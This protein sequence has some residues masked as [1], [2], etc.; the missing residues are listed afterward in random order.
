MR[1]IDALSSG[2]DA[3]IT[4]A[5]ETGLN[6]YLSAPHPRDIAAYSSSTVSDISRAAFEHLLDQPP[7]QNA[8]DYG[9]VLD[10]IRHRVR[11]ECGLPGDTQIVF[12]ASGTD[13]EYV[14]LAATIGK[15]AKGVHNILLGADEIGSGCI[16][17]AN[18]AYFANETALGI[19]VEPADHVAGCGPV[20]MVDVPVRCGEGVARTS[21][22]ISAAIRAEI[23]TAQAAHKHALVHGVHGSKTGLVL[24]SLADIDAMRAEFAGDVTFVIDA[25]QARITSGALGEYVKR[26][27]IVLLTGSKFVGAPPFSGFALVPQSQVDGAA[28]L[29]SGFA[30]IFNRAEWP[31]SWPGRECLPGGCN[32]SLALRLEAAIFEIERFQRLP[33]RK[34]KAILDTFEECLE[35]A[36]I[37]PLGVQRVLP[38]AIGMEAAQSQRPIEMRT[39]MTLDLSVL[40]GLATFDEAQGVHRRLALEA[41]IRLGQP[42]K[43]V[44]IASGWGGT[45]RIGLS[46]PLISRFA[47]MT[48]AD[49]RAIMLRDFTAIADWLRNL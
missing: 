44:R 49:A 19:P 46:M 9:R 13:L 25:C 8:A 36:V 3:R 38:H 34:V 12:A 37:T 14:A 47:A 22:A 45:L 39:L 7:V 17:S 40:P 18:G 6:K 20:S 28:N 30:T 21:E 4:L 1:L 26:D 24:P 2:G 15:A 32:A 23:R 42:V 10:G 27:C 33:V 48:I 11:R 5:P 16:H 29:P 35:D 31:H 41:G 43:C